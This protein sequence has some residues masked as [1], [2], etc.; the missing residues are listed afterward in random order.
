MPKKRESMRSR[1]PSLDFRRNSR[2][3]ARI[4]RPPPSPPRPISSNRPS[5]RL[6]KAKSGA[7]SAA[8][9]D[10]PSTNGNHSRP[11]PST[12][13][14]SIITSTFVPIAAISWNP[15][16]LSEPRV[17]QQVDIKEVPLSIQEHRSHSGWC[18]RCEKLHEAPLPM[19]IKRGGLVGPTLTTQIAFLKGVCHASYSTVRKYVRDVLHVT[20]SRGQ[21]STIIG[22]VTR[23]LELPYQGLLESLP[24]EIVLNIDETGHKQNK[25]RQW[26]WCFRAELYT[27]FKID[28][29]RSADVLID[30]LGAEFNGVLGCDY[31]SAYRRYH[32]ECRRTSPVLF[33]PPDPRCEVPD[34]AARC[35]GSGVWHEVARVVAGN[36]WGDSS[37]GTDAD[38]AVSGPARSGAG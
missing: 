2:R 12:P 35:E 4:L 9:P 21:L 30:V 34:D 5:L 32:R 13:G 25:Q 26:I 20:I 24:G 38:R 31:F 16:L 37:P 36:V 14:S 17:V 1:P 27:L 23:A 15:R 7:T 19:G 10:T 33:G 18:S 29:T 22:K 11:K 8:N 28:L 3:P 6:L